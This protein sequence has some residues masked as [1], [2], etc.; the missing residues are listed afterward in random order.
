MLLLKGLRAKDA[1]MA[2]FLGLALAVAPHPA[3][4][5]NPYLNY[6]KADGGYVTALNSTPPV[7]QPQ[8]IV[9]APLDSQDY[10]PPVEPPVR[11]PSSGAVENANVVSGPSSEATYVVQPGDTAALISKKVFGTS[12]KWQE[13]LAQN[14]ISDG[15]NL[16][17]GQTLRISASANPQVAI[18][19]QANEG[20]MRTPIALPAPIQ[21]QKQAKVEPSKVQEAD[22]ETPAPEEGAQENNNLG[23]NVKM[24]KSKKNKVMDGE[25]ADAN[26]YG[27]SGGTYIIQ[28]N[29]TLAKIAKKVLG[30]SK[31]WREIAKANPKLNPNK[32]VAGH[33]IR[34]PGEE[35]SDD[36]AQNTKMARNSEAPAS[37]DAN[38][39]IPGGPPS[40]EPPPV[41]PPPSMVPP[42]PGMMAPPPPA[43]SGAP[44]P[45]A[46][47]SIEAPPAPNAAPSPMLSSSS[48]YNETRVQLPDELKPTEFT[49]YFTNSNGSYGMFNTEAAFYPFVRTWS[50]GF[51]LAYEK[52]TY[53]NGV[54][55]VID[56]RQWVMPFNLTYVAKKLMVGLSIPFQDWAVTRAGY[57]T[58]T[59]TLTG[60]GDPELKI[61]YQIW[62]NLEGT[63][64]V[65]LHVMGRFPG[66]NYHQPFND[67]SGKTRVGVRVGPTGAT[68]GGWAELGGAY[69]GK[70][71]DRWTSH[72]NLAIANDS[73]D[74]LTKYV[75]RTALD[76][77]VNHNFS[78]VVELNSETYE[79]QNGPDGGNVD[80]LLGMIL[81]NERWQGQLGFPM[82]LQ[83]D[84]GYGHNFGVNLAVNHKWD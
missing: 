52:Y 68:R 49:P 26:F 66:D 32:L 61:G 28:K 10:R 44:T 45:L 41:A 9:A 13:L 38:A 18:D 80:F 25:D 72:L 40:M 54:E 63:H 82:A 69:S 51:H 33:K 62:K 23:G 7:I 15:R 3:M 64:A 21:V 12:A 56:G 81:F 39:P 78:L 79:M 22:Y 70:L 17:V 76:Y 37:F 46:P 53:L 83:K 42:S 24:A 30:S 57:I 2:I 16:R 6:A 36:E 34:I 65:T 27:Q 29:D 8:K 58:P 5:Q 71:S 11:I 4:G 19:R 47:P 43:F 48:P 31:R 73:E 67:M 74:S 50:A 35:G 55:K 59:V 77:R 20:S 60:M 1:L 14:G 84:W 75:A